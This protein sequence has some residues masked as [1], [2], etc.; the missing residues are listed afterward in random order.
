MALRPPPSQRITRLGV[1]VVTLVLFFYVASVITSNS[2]FD[3]VLSHRLAPEPSFPLGQDDVRNGLP[4]TR[5]AERDLGDL[6]SRIDIVPGILPNLP[7]GS[8]TDSQTVS[9]EETG[10][11][12]EALATIANDLTSLALR[13]L[14]GTVAGGL[15]T[16]GGHGPL[17]TGGPTA[18]TAYPGA[19]VP[20]VTVCITKTIAIQ[21]L[22]TIT[23][24]STV[25]MGGVASTSTV[26]IN[27][28]C[29]ATPPLSSTR[30]Q[31]LCNALA[32]ASLSPHGPLMITPTPTIQKDASGWA[33]AG[34]WADQPHQPV[35]GEATN[36][37]F[38]RPLTNEICVRH[39]LVSG[40][41]L[42]A[43]S[44]GDQC[45]CGQF[46]N[47]TQKL[48]DASQCATPCV[49][50]ETR[51]CGGDWA[52]SCYSPDGQARGWAQIGSEQ[53]NP[54]V[55]DPPTVLS[56]VAGGVGA[57]VVTVPAMIFPT[58]GADLSQLQGQYGQS[59]QLSKA[60]LPSGVGQSYGGS[61]GFGTNQPYGDGGSGP[62]PC[63]KTISPC[64]SEAPNIPNPSMT[65]IG[66][67]SIRTTVPEVGSNPT[68]TLTS[69]GSGI[70]VSPTP[71]GWSPGAVAPNTLAP[72]GGRPT[73]DAYAWPSGVVP[74]GEGPPT[75]ELAHFL[76]LKAGLRWARGGINSG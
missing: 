6:T 13:P 15:W 71:A 12:L 59:T 2:A 32:P 38:G 18:A 54:E 63:C 36:V 69:G 41:T 67:S 46:L 74:Q 27:L 70:L 34:C 51:A 62:S 5:H 47:G 24:T 25:Y 53:P 10:G 8:A 17:Y 21:G 44:F 49:G 20:T 55:L 76:S 52:L 73:G 35:L 31:T 9:V 43:T 29:P 66:W 28:P 50:D 75:T 68:L 39:C 1:L 11:P 14:E 64:A 22:E 61:Y 40:Y 37:N 42:A 45:F 26:S 3:L 19:S 58:S 7:L 57:A 23:V 56:L 4:T 60:V 16:G 30:P 65:N 48:D 33:Y 72:R